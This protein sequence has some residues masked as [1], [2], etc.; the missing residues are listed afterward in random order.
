MEK[1]IIAKN[2]NLTVGEHTMAVNVIR[3]EKGNLEIQFSDKDL[4][5]MPEGFCFEGFENELIIFPFKS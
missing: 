5:K 4:A 1:K 3:N 2:I